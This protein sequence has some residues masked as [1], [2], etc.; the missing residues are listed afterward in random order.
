MRTPDRR[1]D[2]KPPLRLVPWCRPA[3]PPVRLHPDKPH[4]H[5][6]SLARRKEGTGPWPT[7]SGHARAEARARWERR[8]DAAMG[9]FIAFA[10]GFFVGVCLR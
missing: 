6:L 7:H 4:R 8:M 10:A 2:V 1:E 3:A 5:I 9:L